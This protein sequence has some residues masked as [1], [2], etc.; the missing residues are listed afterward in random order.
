MHYRPAEIRTSFS[1][2]LPN[3]PKF[4][5][6]NTR[7]VPRYLSTNEDAIRPSPRTVSRAIIENSAKTKGT[8]VLPSQ[9]GFVQGPV[10]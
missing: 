2:R 7:P 4:A 6:R 5:E 8:I 9:N 1:T 3:N 10:S